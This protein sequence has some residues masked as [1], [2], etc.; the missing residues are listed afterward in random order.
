MQYGIECNLDEIC[1][2]Q[3]DFLKDAQFER[4]SKFPILFSN[5]QSLI[6]FGRLKKNL[7]CI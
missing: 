2:I 1:A 5:D 3:K 7:K 6:S 4:L